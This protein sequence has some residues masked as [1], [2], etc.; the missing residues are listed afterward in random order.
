MKSEFS[1]NSCPRSCMGGKR[2]Q[3][4]SGDGNL[5]F[6][7]DAAERQCSIE[8]WKAAVKQRHHAPQGVALCN[9]ML[10]GTQDQGRAC[11]RDKLRARD[12]ASHEGL[13]GSVAATIATVDK[14]LQP[15]GTLDGV[16][17]A[18][19]SETVDQFERPVPCR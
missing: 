3:G 9:S 15:A 17:G 5:H 13:G 12:H 10:L 4:Q 1:A 2:K 7:C 18:Q 6:A 11:V 19:W 14:L 16:L 8:C